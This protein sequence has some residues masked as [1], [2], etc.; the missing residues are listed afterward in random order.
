M[1]TTC[2]NAT[3]AVV[4]DRLPKAPLLAPG[5]IALAL[6]LRSNHSVYE[7]IHE[8]NMSAIRIGNKVLISRDEVSKWINN[9][10]Y[11]G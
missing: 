6:G 3:A 9:L 10:S 11:Q 5:D 2:L 4:I 8:G 7:A 1:S